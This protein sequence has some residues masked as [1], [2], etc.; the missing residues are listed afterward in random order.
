[1]KSKQIKKDKGKGKPFFQI[2]TQYTKKDNSITTLEPLAQ[3]LVGIYESFFYFYYFSIF[4]L[5]KKKKK[6]LCVDHWNFDYSK[7]NSLEK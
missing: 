2:F 5:I 3:I 1:L 7:N 4:Y 6:K